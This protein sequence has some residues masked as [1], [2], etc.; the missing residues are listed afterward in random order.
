MSIE[1]VAIFGLGLIGGSLGLALKARGVR[2]VGVERSDMLQ[3]A[4][5]RAVSGSVIDR[6][7]DSAVR[8]AYAAAD[9]VVLA[10]PVSAIVAELPRA[11]ASATA[12]TDVGSTKRVIAAASN[13]APHF[14]P[15][16]PMAGGSSSGAEHSRS[17]LFQGRRWILCSEGRSA[18][19]VERVEELLT[20]V[21]AVVV[22]LDAVDHD[23]AVAVTSHVPQLLASWLVV[24]AERRGSTPVSGAGFAAA[25]QTAGANPTIWRDI[26]ATNGDFIGEA[27]T[28]LG[29]EIARIAQQ[30]KA[31][32][33]S[34]GVELI[35]EARRLRGGTTRGSG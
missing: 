3:R 31:G 35:E 21:G 7:D 23:R 22:R 19:V 6:A 5:V 33:P 27:L 26:L 4:E 24:L 11:L 20:L 28:D 1:N 30:L 12:V 15:G 25:T 29:G 32:D 9:L 17:D 34:S 2:V 8:A 10:A 18:A 13:G 14:V 16:H